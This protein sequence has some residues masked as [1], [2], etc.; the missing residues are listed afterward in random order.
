MNQQ[1]KICD[2]HFKKVTLHAGKLITLDREI[3]WLFRETEQFPR[4]R[5]IKKR[6]LV[7]LRCLRRKTSSLVQLYES[8]CKK[9][10]EF[11][12]EKT[13]TFDYHFV[14]GV[15]AYRDDLDRSQKITG[16]Y[17]LQVTDGNFVAWLGVHANSV[18]L[19][20]SESVNN[21]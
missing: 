18:V 8:Y 19:I 10:C 13:Y 15:T 3:D 7:L 2:E 14:N 21:D 1:Q 11:L 4:G 20:D 16:V 9:T 5:D 12:E 6:T 17:F